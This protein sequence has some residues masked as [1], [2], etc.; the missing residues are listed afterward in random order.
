MRGGRKI[1]AAR[2]VLEGSD[3]SRPRSKTPVQVLDHLVA[4]CSDA[5]A[6]YRQAAHAVDDPAVRSVLE[7]NAS[8]RE[9]IASVLSYKLAELGHEPKPDGSLA[10]ALHRKIID[11]TASVDH[12]DTG[13]LLR[14]CASG[15]RE[16]LAQFMAAL[17]QPLPHDVHEVVQS[18]LGRVLSASAALQGAAQNVAR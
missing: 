9:E 1:R 17:G 12:G 11:L 3:V 16:T 6:G 2:A 13:A 15:E 18:Q 7:Q 14:L 8:E 5:V 10:G 4:L